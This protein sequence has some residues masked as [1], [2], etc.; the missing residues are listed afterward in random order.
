MTSRPPEVTRW[1]DPGSG[2]SEVPPE[3]R[4]LLEMSRQQLGTPAEVALLAQ[5]L[6]R[7]LPEAGLGNSGPSGL[8]PVPVA[9]RFRAWLAAG[10]AVLTGAVTWWMLGSR[11]LPEP[12]LAAPAPPV[13]S[14]PAEPAPAPEPPEPV[15]AAEVTP[16]PT[17]ERASALKRAAPHPRRHAASKASVAEAELLE[18]AQAAL[19]TRP[20]DA[21]A[22]T[23][24]HQRRFP[25]GLLVQEREV[26]AIDALSRLG[27]KRAASAKAA[28][29]EER[30]RGSVHQPRLDDDRDRGPAAGGSGPDVD[31]G[32]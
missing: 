18:R 29:F 20:K 5:S 22:L 14:Q 12:S 27:Q 32:P 6:A 11:S 15:V 2:S 17:A 30:Y 19:A 9:A 28:E 3:L 13:T 4:R 21:L 24:E 10:G 16:E 25:R 23:R 31:P 26:I 1:T 8:A 7:A